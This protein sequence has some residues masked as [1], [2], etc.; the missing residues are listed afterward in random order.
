MNNYLGVC[1]GLILIIF[2][3][4]GCSTSNYGHFEKLPDMNVARARHKSF[5][6]KDGRVLLFG[7]DGSV[8]YRDG[9]RFVGE[10][11]LKTAEIY[12]PKTN[13]FTM[14]KGFSQIRYAFNSIML[15]DGRVLITGGQRK[16]TKALKQAEIY[17]PISDTLT[18]IPD[19]N[20]TRRSHSNI[21]LKDGKILIFGGWSG[22][23][24]EKGNKYVKKAELYDPIQNKF[25][26]LPEYLNL[27]YSREII[28]SCILNDSKVF[29]V[30][31][32]NKEEQAE[33]FDPI[34]K[35]FTVLDK[36][37]SNKSKKHYND[38]YLY[39]TILLENDKIVLF[40]RNRNQVSQ[41]DIYDY[42]TNTIQRV[43][44]SSIKNRIGGSLVKLDENNIL[45]SNSSAWGFMSPY[46]VGRPEIFNTD[47]LKFHKLP[48][49]IYGNI[50]VSSIR[51]K[52]GRVLITGGHGKSSK[53]LKVS[54]MFI[55]KDYIKEK[56]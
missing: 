54:E 5:L 14:T 15:D 9:W 39:K 44:S 24:G 20:F 3:L 37:L 32:L 6:M 4:L 30:K 19:M 16:G 22:R 8:R 47:T 41:F 46:N 53:Y 45:I 17:D 10:R 36:K 18:Q 33:L 11:A 2:C 27:K 25:E 1:L 49:M 55:P 52:D 51:L 21:K 48:G 13:S 26:I 29:I 38:Y 40:G 23:V 34:T 43:G 42:K 50:G 28:G 35:Q 7:G 56:K 31:D 12:D